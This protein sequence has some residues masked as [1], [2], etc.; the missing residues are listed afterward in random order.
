MTFFTSKTF[1]FRTSILALFIF[2]GAM[3]SGAQPLLEQSTVGKSLR[4]G[5]VLEYTVKVKG[6][7]AGTRIMQIRGKK[8]HGGR[9]VY[10]IASRSFINK[11]FNIL[12]QYSEESESLIL[13][14]RF[15]PLYYGKKL[16]DGGYIGNTSISFDDSK[17]VARVIKDR[18][19]REIKIPKGIQDELSMIYL[20]RTKNVV[21]GEQYEF[22]ALI[23]NET[24]KIDVKVLRYEELKTVL[25]KVNTIVVKSVPKN[26]T[27]WLTYDDSRIPVRLEADTKLGK[28]VA[29][30]K[31]IS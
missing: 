25:G 9:E 21:I 1:M 15:Y 4:L 6:I 2:L 28:I 22:P 26:V 7:P 13:K 10:E 27:L 16:R 5:E 31:S 18:K 30:L 20:V 8:F 11:I 3:V 29:E 17:K 19:S 12:Y 14:D 23:G 24:V